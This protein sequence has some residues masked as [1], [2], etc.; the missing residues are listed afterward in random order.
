MWPRSVDFMDSPLAGELISIFGS[1]VAIH[2]PERETYSQDA[3][4]LPSLLTSGLNRIPVA[5]VQPQSKEELGLLVALAVKHKVPVTQRGAGTAGYGGAVPARGGI[6]ADCWRMNRILQVDESGCQVEVE[7]GIRCMEMD[8]SLRKHGLSLKSYPSSAISATLGG[9]LATGKGAGIGSYRSG[10]LADLISE[11]ELVTPSGAIVLGKDSIGMVAC[12]SG[13]TGIISRIKLEVQRACDEAVLVAV[14]DTQGTFIK[15]LHIIKEKDIPLWHVGFSS[16]RQQ[17]LSRQALVSQIKRDKIHHDPTDFPVFDVPNDS[18][19]GTFVGSKSDIET[20]AGLVE[21]SGGR[22]LDEKTADFIWK[23]RFYPMRQKPLGPSIVPGEI[24]V[25]TEKIPELLHAV[26]RKLDKEFTVDGTLVNGG[27]ETVLLFSFLDDER[28]RGFSL[29][30]VKS[31]SLLTEAKK[32]GGQ[33]YAIGMLLVSEAKSYWDK[34]T[35]HKIYQ[36]KSRVDPDHIM[37]PGKIFP[38]RMAKSPHTRYLEILSALG[39]TFSPMVN[40]VDRWLRHRSSRSLAGERLP[41]AQDNTPSPGDYRW[42]ALACS[43]CGYCQTVCT[44]FNVFG[45]ES[46]SPRG[47]FAFLRGYKKGKEHFDKRLADMFFMCSTCRR[48]DGICQSRI[49][50]LQHWDLSVRPEIWNRGYKLPLFHQD[51]TENVLRE[52]NP[53]GNV[54]SKRDEFLTPDIHY[55]E[56]GET[57]YWV[58]CTASYAMM[59]IAQNALRILNAGGLEP[60]L[61]LQDEWCCGSDILLYGRIEDISGTVAHNVEALKKRGVK[62]LIAHCPGCWTAFSLYYP[63]LLDRVGMKW[64]IRVEHFTETVSGLVRNHKLQMKQPVS[65]KVTYHDSCHLGRRGDIYE[66]PREVLRAIPGI[67]LVEMPQ[68]RENAPCCGRQLFQFTGS[69]PKPYV[70]RAIEAKGTGASHLVNNCPGCQVA[71]ILGARE[72]GISDLKCVDITD[73]ICASAGI[74]TMPYKVTAKVAHLGYDSSVKPKIDAD[75]SRTDAL[76]APHKDTYD[77]LSKG[78]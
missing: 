69:G 37:N 38:S 58:G 27:S 50:I 73:I 29:S 76:F 3:G 67:E 45:W 40:P 10:Y 72:A 15:V 61:L 5:V 49:P 70:D 55:K 66:A 68:N 59:G 54:H 56:E 32:L 42:D 6:V 25:P 48:C 17:K 16:A 2:R 39:K 71:Y 78:K 9:W 36:F 52:H 20:L 62:K 63:I 4:V 35:L 13:T 77:K 74:A 14:F 53:A 12:L 23:E 46:A 44:E 31:L 47:K 75:K 33:P 26:E 1:R 51:T 57:A 43:R 24:I 65:L 41:S 30:Y 22:V 60:V 7:P 28:R 8:K 21:D 34:E 18:V 11:V 19:Y 64:D